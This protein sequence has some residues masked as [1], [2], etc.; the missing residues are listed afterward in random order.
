MRLPLR[1][2]PSALARCCAALLAALCG[3]SSSAVTAAAPGGHA[4]APQMSVK[5]LFAPASDVESGVL[6][7]PPPEATPTRS[8]ALVFVDAFAPQSARTGVVRFRFQHGGGALRLMPL[9]RDASVWRGRLFAGESEIPLAGG[10][11]L[12]AR[13]TEQ[14]ASQS[15]FGLDESTRVLEL[16]LPAGECEVEF[17]AEVPPGTAAVLVVDAG[18]DRNDGPALVAQLASRVNRAGAGFELVVRGESRPARGVVPATTRGVDVT[19][20]TVTWSDGVVEHARGVRPMRDGSVRVGFASARRGNAVVRVDGLVRDSRGS[21]HQRSLF[22]LARISDGARIAGGAVV[23][24]VNAAS[25]WIDCDFAVSHADPGDALFAC[26]EL[27]AVAGADFRVL[28]WIGGI[29]TIESHGRA[30]F[31]RLGFDRGQLGLGE[32]ERLVFRN[33]R[34]HE[35]DGF[36]PLDVREEV[37]PEMRVA[38]PNRREAEPRGPLDWAGPAGIAS[39]AVPEISS[40][41]PPVG[42]H[43]L[44]LSHGYCASS[45]PWPLAQ[46]SSDAWPYANLG[47]NLSNDVFAVDLATRAAQ[48]KSYGIIGHSQGGNAALHLHTFY[49]SGLDWAGSGRL[50]QCVGSP[51]EGTPLAGNLAA[52]GQALGIQCGANFDITPDGAAAWL[53]GIPTASRAKLFTHTTTFTNVPFVYDYCSIAT[54]FFLSDPEDGVVEHSSGHIVGAQDMGLRTGWCHVGGM[55]DPAQTGDANRNATMNA[56]G[57]R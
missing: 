56:Q 34:L 9:G 18:A 57:A 35:R 14:F 10:D 47:Q 45:N 28:G 52:F 46:F 23:H 6:R 50:M 33:V 48:F 31:V 54:D 42:G 16:E 36:A 19:G 25:D 41:V 24:A 5:R 11:A 17:F 27:W 4:D 39:V 55:R 15:A 30:P 53:A 44:V 38:L 8:H 21:Q 22:Y 29:A 37:V 32:G 7:L 3:A 2:R 51:L 26:A 13:V 49:W 43:A 1:P 12:V 20:A 40:L